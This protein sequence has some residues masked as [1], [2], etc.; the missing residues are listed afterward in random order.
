MTVLEGSMTI[1]SKWNSVFRRTNEKL[2]GLESLSI[3]PLCDGVSH[4]LNQ[5]SSNNVLNKSDQI[6][7]YW[8]H[9]HG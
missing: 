1:M 2:K 8:S 7:C 5:F 6:K 3:Q 9:T 4:A